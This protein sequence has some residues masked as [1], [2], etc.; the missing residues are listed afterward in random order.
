MSYGLRSER[1]DDRAFLLR[2]YASTRAQELS[3]VPWPEAQK[4]MFVAMQFDA[5]ARHFRTQY[6]GARWRVIEVD[7]APVGRLYVDEGEDAIL[8][9]DIALLPEVR[10]RGLGRRVMEEV[11]RDA[12][13]GRKSVALHVDRQNPARRLY[14]SLGFQIQADDGGIYLRMAWQ[15]E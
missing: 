15:P 7:G 12:A 6:R 11:M 3:L 8:V 13:A 14:E 4:A 1:P 5:Q 2:L 9:V 10:G